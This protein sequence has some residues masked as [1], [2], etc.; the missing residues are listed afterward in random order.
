MPH[1]PALEPPALGCIGT[2]R[3]GR[4]SEG[5][6][7]RASRGDEVKVIAAA[8]PGSGRGRG[9]VVSVALELAEV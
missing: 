4:A 7:G 5:G 6:V 9:C 8:Q 1:S 2:G 3:R